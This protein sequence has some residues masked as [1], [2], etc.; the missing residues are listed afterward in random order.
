MQ[1]GIKKVFYF[2]TNASALGGYVGHGSKGEGEF[3]VI[4]SHASVS[5]PSAGGSASSKTGKRPKDEVVSCKSTYTH[6]SGHAVQKNGPWVTRAT[7]V[8]EGLNILGVLKA[9]RVVSQIFLEHAASGGP[10]RIAFGRSHFD[11]LRLNGKQVVITLNRTLFPAS[12]VVNNDFYD[13]QAVVIPTIKAPLLY[14]IA[15]KQSKAFLT[16]PKVPDWVARRH[17][18]HAE[19]GLGPE[20]HVLCS[21]VEKVDGVDPVPTYGHVMDVPDIGRFYFGELILHSKSLQL[22]MVRAE[23]GCATTGSVS[24]ASARANGVPWPPGK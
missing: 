15:Q 11:N 7:A 10:S 24:A 1:A 21:I 3:R 4:P 17:G 22:T 14:K 12:D 13:E 20:D 5:L 16:L 19:G 18:V 2:N 6:V 8:V 23:L 9:D